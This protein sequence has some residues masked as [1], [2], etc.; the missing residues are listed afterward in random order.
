[1]VFGQVPMDTWIIS[2]SSMALLI[3][4]KARYTCGSSKSNSTSNAIRLVILFLA[5]SLRMRKL[6]IFI[7]EIRLVSVD[8]GEFSMSI[9]KSL[10]FLQTEEGIFLLLFSCSAWGIYEDAE[11]CHGGSNSNI[12][13][14]IGLVRLITTILCPFLAK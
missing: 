7:H 13:F 2:P 1:M 6:Y 11:K 4:S 9:T 5:F 14:K 3:L 10:F 12:F 8:V